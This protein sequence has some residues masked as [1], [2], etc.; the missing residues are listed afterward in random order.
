VHANEAQS[1]SSSHGSSEIRSCL[2]DAVTQQEKPAAG[3]HETTKRWC[4]VYPQLLHV[5]H[6]Q[7]K[8]SHAFC[9]LLPVNRSRTGY[10]LVS[11]IKYPWF[12]RILVIKLC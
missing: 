6:C 12:V 9:Y 2:M 10:Q 3:H 11:A 7:R 8:P 5:L 4:C 1:I